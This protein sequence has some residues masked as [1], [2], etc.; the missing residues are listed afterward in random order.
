MSTSLGRDRLLAASATRRRFLTLTGASAAAALSPWLLGIA[1]GSD[2][3][4]TPRPSG[5]P[6]ALGVAS[7]DPLPTAVVIWTRL[8][9]DPLAPFGGMDY[10]RM[11]VEWQVA[12]DENFRRVVRSGSVQAVPEWAHSVHVDVTGLR[13]ARQYF[14]R[15]RCG[16]EVSPVG[17]TRTAPAA[18][19]SLD[20]FSFA[21]VSCQSWTSGYYT[22]YADLARY[23]YELVV[24][25]GDYLYEYGARPE[26]ARQAELPT[27]LRYPTLG[28]TWSLDQYRDQY[29]LFKADPDL[30][31]AHA[32]APWITTIDDHEVAD[33]WADEA[34]YDGEPWETFLIRRANAFRAHWEHMPMRVP[35]PVGPDLPLYRRFT[36][37]DLMEL[38]ILDTRQYRSPIVAQASPEWQDPDRSITGAEQEAWLLDGMGAS[39][40]RW[41][42]IGQQNAIAQ[43]D[44]RAGAGQTFGM[45]RWDGY[46]ASRARVLGGIHERG[47]GNVISIGGDLHRSIASDLALDAGD[48]G[49][50]LVAAEFV[51]TSI[52]SG[53]DGVDID[54][55]G[56]RTLAENPH[57]KYVNVQR[58]YV[59]CTVTPD[60]W[61][62]DYRVVEYITRPGAPASTRTSLVVEDGRPGIQAG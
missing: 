6:F 61:R 44:S 16:R 34:A 9:V 15:F 5:Y 40:A 47:V 48:P 7:G 39:T 8:V 24:H 58:G 36:F 33:N 52:S 14:Y 51:G 20:R 56:Q 19:A 25:L 59:G 2:G 37:G 45:D 55:A 41:N 60:L 29:A 43:L 3:P 49:A 38:N 13:P 31:A 62:S 57:V 10:L 42:V 21:F 17:R 4:A 12:E 53:G 23:D 18:N 54:A 35:K 50:P 32:A 30:Q 46:P 22:A 1:S 27:H 26:V 11:P 28:E